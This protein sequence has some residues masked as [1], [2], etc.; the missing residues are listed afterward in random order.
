MPETALPVE[1]SQMWLEVYMEP[2]YSAVPNDPYCLSHQLL[3]NTTS[4]EIRVDG[5]VQQEGVSASI[6]G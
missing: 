4:T 2:L 1:I 5:H 3:A 6:P